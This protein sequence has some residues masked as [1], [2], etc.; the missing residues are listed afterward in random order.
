M[1]AARPILAALVATLA[2]VVAGPAAGHPGGHRTTLSD[3]EDEVMCPT[4][5]T[6]LQLAESPLANRQRAMI[7][8]LV[9]RDRTKDEI[10][11]ALV[12]EFGEEVLA[13]PPRR[14]FALVSYVVP[15]LVLLGV[16]G[17]LLFALRRWR[18]RGTGHAADESAAPQWAEDPEAA[19]LD[20]ELTRR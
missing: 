18:R 16:A 10:K 13:A 4:C 7:L 20:A 19:Q 6:S 9:E 17:S 2:L 1:T 14:G 8:K 11:A 5:G 15:V 3:L 12:R